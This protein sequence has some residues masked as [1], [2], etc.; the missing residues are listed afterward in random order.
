M[1]F[2][3]YESNSLGVFRTPYLDPDEDSSMLADSRSVC[4]DTTGK[5]VR[6]AKKVVFLDE[7]V[8]GNCCCPSMLAIV[9]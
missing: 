5:R 4:S 2:R 3:S 6:F 8:G 7:L 1:V 9:D